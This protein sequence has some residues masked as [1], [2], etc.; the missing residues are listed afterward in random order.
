MNTFN[1][2]KAIRVKTQVKAGAMSAN[3]NQ[4]TVR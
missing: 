3:H 2:S 4:T 1:N